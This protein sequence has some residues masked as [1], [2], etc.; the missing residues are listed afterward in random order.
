MS[1]EHK[2]N[3]IIL[4]EKGATFTHRSQLL[5]VSRA[6]PGE[7]PRFFFVGRRGNWCGGN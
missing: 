5:K 7:P 6:P 4:E 3:N 1:H 2:K